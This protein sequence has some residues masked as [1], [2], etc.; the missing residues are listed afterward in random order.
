MRLSFQTCAK[1]IG[2]ASQIMVVRDNA[3]ELLGIFESGADISGVAVERQQSE[4][5]VAIVR[6]PG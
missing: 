6:M 3:S 5:S 2:G 4:E 1:I